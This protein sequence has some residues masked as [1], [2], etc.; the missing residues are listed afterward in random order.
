[1]TVVLA[2]NF[3]RGII[4]SADRRI[5]HTSGA[6]RDDDTK[7]LLCNTGDVIYS[8][9]M[10][11]IT[12]PHGEVLFD[13][14]V[15]VKQTLESGIFRS[16][17]EAAEDI[18]AN[19]H[20]GVHAYLTSRPQHVWPPYAK[21]PS[22][23]IGVLWR[24]TRFPVE[25]IQVRGYYTPQ[26]A[27]YFTVDAGVET[28]PTDGNW[29]RGFVEPEVME[30]VREYVAKDATLSSATAP[31]FEPDQNPP[32]FNVAKTALESLIQIASQ[33]DSDVS[34]ESESLRIDLS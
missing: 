5:R 10:T 20:Q 31:Y 29:I 6:F 1:M 32:P 11:K 17:D 4:V 26:A 24:P 9:G 8:A 13:A 18:A 7:Y 33:F 27:P 2:A 21:T 12:G 30:R 15:I 25:R 22:L 34:P 23:L 14:D 3:D 19:V 28:L 16:P